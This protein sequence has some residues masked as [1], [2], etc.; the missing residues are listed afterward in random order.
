MENTIAA[1]AA[2]SVE[3][4]FQAAAIESDSATAAD[5]PSA[6]VDLSSSSSAAA[7]GT[8][9]AAAV[10]AADK[11]SA[12]ALLRCCRCR[13]GSDAASLACSLVQ[14]S[15]ITIYNRSHYHQRA[16][17]LL[18]ASATHIAAT[19]TRVTVS[20]RLTVTVCHC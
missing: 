14:A 9:A 7:E 19:Q 10:D 13:P 5:R 3:R 8:A 2:G 1:A 4:C 11:A 15:D 17:T 20:K 6:A 18:S 16:L 12:V